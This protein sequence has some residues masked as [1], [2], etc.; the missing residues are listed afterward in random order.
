LGAASKVRPN[1]NSLVGACALAALVVPTPSL[2]AGSSYRLQVVRAD[3]AA[4]CPGA[5][6]IERD[7]SQRLG[8]QAFSDTGQRGIEVVL[9]RAETK[10]RAKLYLRLEASDTDAVRVLESDASDCAELGKSV[11]LAISLAIAPELPPEPPPAPPPKLEPSCPPPP[12]PKRFPAPRRTLHGEASLRALLS[13][14]LL[15]QSSLGAG[16]A[17]T[18]RGELFGASFGGVFFPE[19]ELRSGSARL[20]FGVSAG[21]ASGCLWARTKDPQV[22][23]CIGARIGALHSVVY[24]PEPEHPGDRFWWAAS[25]E[26][27]LREHVYGRAFVEAGAAAVFPFIRHR[28][29]VDAATTPAY[30]QGPAVVEAFLGFG[31]RLD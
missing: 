2:A 29:Q 18:L 8:R 7:V 14:N 3:G 25:S 4:S 10:W 13:P 15:P 19:N 11:T 5:T 20:G 30:E 27:T 23:S 1:R 21:F 16:L 24:S 28:F 9:E 6:L 12:P 26:L 31:L 17:V 22:S